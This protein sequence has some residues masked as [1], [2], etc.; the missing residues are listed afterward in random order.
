M[1]VDRMPEQL[2]S[3]QLRWLLAAKVVYGASRGFDTS[4]ALFERAIAS[5]G[6]PADLAKALREAGLL[7]SKRLVLRLME[8]GA[9]FWEDDDWKST[10]LDKSADS[11]RNDPE[12]QA[13]ERFG[14]IRR[15]T[16]QERGILASGN[17][18]DI[19][20]LLETGGERALVDNW[21]RMPSD[22]VP[23]AVQADITKMKSGAQQ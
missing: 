2:T 13:A 8:A 16:Q 20:I 4:D 14:R 6:D 18:E 23:D 15:W 10:A 12:V 9:P 3:G 17:L 21:G 11:I 22:L 1:I 5:M 19:R 7:G